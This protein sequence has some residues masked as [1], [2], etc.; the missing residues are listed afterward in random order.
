[1]LADDLDRIAAISLTFPSFADGRAF[2]QART[3][4]DRFGFTGEL[5]A[6]GPV[7]QDQFA[8]LL[9]CGF[10]VVVVPDDID[11]AAW[12]RSAGRFTNVYQPAADQKVP[13]YRAR[14]VAPEAQPVAATAGSH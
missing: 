14:H 1:M 3:L 7:I 12:N 5:R 9:R 4:R 8:F 11:V 6:V 10:D 13:A 2:S